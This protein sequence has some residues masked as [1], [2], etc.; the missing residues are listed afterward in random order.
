MAV[1]IINNCFNMDSPKSVQKIGLFKIQPLLKDFKLLYPTYVD[2][3]V[4]IDPDIK[5]IILD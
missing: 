3:L 4:Q 1:A 2:V 5:Q